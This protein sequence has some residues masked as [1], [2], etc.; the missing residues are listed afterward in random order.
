MLSNRMKSAGGWV[1]FSI[2]GLFWLS[3]VGTLIYVAAHFLVKFW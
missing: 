2:I 3:I 1:V